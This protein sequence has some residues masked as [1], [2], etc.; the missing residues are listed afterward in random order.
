[1]RS[2]AESAPVL[3]G[4]VSLSRIARLWQKLRLMDVVLLT[5]V[6][7][8]AVVLLIGD[9]MVSALRYSEFD[10]YWTEGAIRLTAVAPTGC[11]C[12]PARRRR[13]HASTPDRPPRPAEPSGRT[14]CPV[15]ATSVG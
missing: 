7:L 6:P 5:S 9:G 10:D 4:V 15:S 2:R 14:V 3:A 11:G 1:M 12:G 13:R 8:L